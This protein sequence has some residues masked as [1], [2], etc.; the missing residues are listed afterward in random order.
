MKLALSLKQ[1]PPPKTNS[2][3]LK[4]YIIAL[5]NI[6]MHE[7]DVDNLEE[8][9]KILLKGLR[10]CD[11][12]EVNE[13][14]DGRA[15]LHHNLGKVYLELREWNKAKNHIEIEV[16]ICK[17]IGHTQ[18]EVKGVINLGELHYRVQKHD[19]AILCYQ[20]A[21][22]IAK[23]MKNEDS[24]VDLISQNVETVNEASKV[25]ELLIKDEQKLKRLER[26]TSD[27][28]GTANE[29]KFLLEQY[30]SLDSL[31]E[32]SMLIFA[33]TKHQEF[34]KMKKRVATEL[35]D[36]GKL[37]DS[38]LVMGES[39]QKLRNF[40]K[41]LKWYMKSWNAYRSIGNL[42]GQ[43]LA[44]INVGEVLDSSGDWVGALEAFKEGYRISVEAN[45]PSLQLSAL[46]NMHFSHMIRF[47]N[48][49]ETRKLHIEIQNVERLLN[50]GEL[51]MRVDQDYCSET[52]TEGVV[53]SLLSSDESDSLEINNPSIFEDKPNLA[54]G[55]DVDVD[56][57]LRMLIEKSKKSSKMEM[58]SLNTK[59]KMSDSS[60]E[61]L[62][63]DLVDHDVNLQ[64]L[65]RKRVR[66]IISD[67]EDEEPDQAAQLRKMNHGNP[68]EDV[69]T[70]CGDIR[71]GEIA[72]ST[73]GKERGVED[74]ETNKVVL[75]HGGGFGGWCWYKTMSLLGDAGF[76]VTAINLAGSVTHSVDANNITSLSE[77]LNPLITF[78]K[79]LGGIEKVILVGHDFGGTCISYA[80][81]AFPAK[82]AKSVFLAAFMLKNGQRTVDM[83][84]QEEA[85]N[86]L[87]QQA[88]IFL[89]ANGKDQTPTAIC[90]ETSLLKDLL[91][92]QSPT[93]DITLASGL[94]RPIPFAP[95][96]EEL[97][98]TNIKY[99]S[100]R[101][102][103]IETT[104][105]N[106][107]PLPLQQRLCELNP[108]EKVFRLEG[109][110]HSP[111]F[112]K[113]QAL[114]KI[115]VEIART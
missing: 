74:L 28:R 21:M 23:R 43:A 100:V 68:I 97:E 45:L 4:E 88:Q 17:R 101:R 10:I 95:I 38:F 77:Y 61:R 105:D 76:E 69:A 66:L 115:L 79:K 94:M 24:L 51:L 44:K 14:D 37:G 42:Q 60:G 83:L 62:N 33:W 96:L 11:E 40:G 8:A 102:F 70:S 7:M 41:A 5:N 71:L 9:E 47:D 65:G 18:D 20:K 87:M 27:A 19:E 86:E 12:E 39:Y 13:Y 15:Q 59:A 91:F 34:A 113:P 58:S 35:C 50:G 22:D 89:H 81:E 25:L 29:R 75:V 54:T 67:E 72:G 85:T 108:P 114:H 56:V 1:N 32:K 48:V 6:G 3:F 78:L 106:A 26:A 112:S 109:S 31:I 111:F 93:M 103:Y 80:M 52:E 30:V 84:S 104:E 73:A 99:G 90:L 36:K 64:S 49:D 55:D 46:Q 16:L 107:L 92:N 63:R 82:I 57:P 110:D 53:A 98:L 2:F